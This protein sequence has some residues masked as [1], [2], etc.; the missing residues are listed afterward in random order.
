M[1]K[2]CIESEVFPF[3]KLDNNSQRKAI[4]K[5]KGS[6]LSLIGAAV[7]NHHQFPATL[8]GLQLTIRFQDLPQDLSSI[9]RGKQNG[10]PYASGVVLRLKPSVSR[11]VFEAPDGLNYLLRCTSLLVPGKLQ[12]LMLVSYT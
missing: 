1:F 7:I 3:A 9:F 10:Q 8:R 5:K 6:L 12:R 2:A 11:S 4:P